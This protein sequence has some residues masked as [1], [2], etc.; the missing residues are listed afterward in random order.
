ADPV[1]RLAIRY[2][3]A[4]RSRQTCRGVAAHAGA[5]AGSR[6]LRTRRI[7]AGRIGRLEVRLI[8][9]AALTRSDVLRIERALID[10]VRCLV[11][12]RVYVRRTAITRARSRL[13]LVVRAAVHT[14]LHA[15]AIRIRERWAGSA[16]ASERS[17]E[18]GRRGNRGHDGSAGSAG[19]LG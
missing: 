9:A 13:Q 19:R 7:A 18:R 8:Q 2:E 6:S 3:L 5:I 11:A 1:R 14:I 10:A 16:I 15:V 17:L 4:A 12:V